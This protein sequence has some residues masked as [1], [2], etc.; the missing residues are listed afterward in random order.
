MDV[1]GERI[2]PTS[3]PIR[4]LLD[5]PSVLMLPMMLLR[6]DMLSSSVDHVSCKG[7]NA[8]V[9]KAFLSRNLKS[10]KENKFNVNFP[11][12]T[13]EGQLADVHAMIVD[14]WS[15]ATLQW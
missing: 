8:H 5:W 2:P 15:R 6:S 12:I 11:L 13:S 9:F 14:L 3:T 10:F 4:N 1:K 7:I